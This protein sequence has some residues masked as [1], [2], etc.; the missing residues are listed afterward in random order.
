MPEA[1]DRLARAPWRAILLA[2]PLLALVLVGCDEHP[3]ESQNLV[4]ADPRS[5][6]ELVLRLGCGACHVIPGVP[7]LRGRVGPS[8]QAFAQRRYIAGTLPNVPP[9]L[10]EWV[11][12][13]P[14]LVPQTA[15]PALPIGE[16]E[17]RDIAAYLY[18]LR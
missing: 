4:L 9:V 13:A 10:V 5:G 7:G 18:T 15:M 14:S 6:R 3:P 11:R 8:L 17:A 1:E 16:N 2:A 12:D